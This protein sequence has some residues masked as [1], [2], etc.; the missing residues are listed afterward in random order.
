MLQMRAQRHKAKVGTF[1]NSLLIIKLN[2][3][4]TVNYN[5]QGK[6]YHNLMLCPVIFFT[7]SLPTLLIC[8]TVYTMA[9]DRKWGRGKGDF[10]YG[11]AIC[12]VYILV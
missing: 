9:K 5:R 6:G 12:R 7:N 2:L 3:S 11:L 10:W 1:C 4:F 8:C